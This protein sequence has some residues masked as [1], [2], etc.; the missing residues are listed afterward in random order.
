MPLNATVKRI[1]NT[2][3][4]AIVIII[5]ALAV[6]LVGMRLFGFKIFTVLS[7]SMEPDIKTGALIY[8]RDVE[9]NELEVNDVITFMLSEDM[10]AT[11]RIVEII[12]DDENPSILRFRTKGDANDMEDAGLVHQNNIIG[13][14]KLTIPYLGYLTNYIQHPPGTYIA[15]AGGAILLI[16][17][18][19]PDIFSDDGKKD[20]RHKADKSSDKASDGAD[21]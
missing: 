2:V 15:I 3:T 12:P 6:A 16:L 19:L 17:V 4:T 1:W 7:G 13:E 11:H 5:V 10:V 20:S 8:V 9:P 14:M 21:I 18:F